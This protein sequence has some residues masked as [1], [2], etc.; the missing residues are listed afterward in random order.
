[1]AQFYR[2]GEISGNSFSLQIAA[3]M[4]DNI[5]VSGTGESSPV[6]L[7]SPN[8]DE[9]NSLRSTRSLANLIAACVHDPRVTRSFLRLTRPPRGPMPRNTVE[10]LANLA[11]NPG[12]EVEPIYRL[13]K[14]GSSYE[15]SLVQMPDAWTITV[16]VNN[17]GDDT[18]LIGGPGNLAFDAR[19]YAWVT[20]N[21]DQGTPYSSHVAMV[22]KPNGQP[23]DGT[24]GT[25]LSPLKGG[26]LL[27]AGFG[28][29]IDPQGSAWFGNFGWGNCTGC[30]PDPDGN[31]SV[32]QFA[33]SGAPISGSLGYQGGPVRAQGMAFDAEG[34]LWISSFGNDSIYVFLHGD[35]NQSVGFQ[36]NIGSGPFDVA[37]AADGSA[38]VSNGL[39]KPPSSVAKYKLVNGAVELQFRR[40]VGQGLRGLSLDSRGNAWVAS[41]GDHFVYVLRPDGTE[42]GRF[43][44]GG[45]EGPW[46]TAIDGE[47]NVWVTNFGPLEP[48]SNFTSGRLTKLAGVHPPP[49][50]NFGDPI[51]PPTGY[52]VHSAGS[53]VLLHNG[54]PLYGA[55]APPSFAPMM[56]QTG[57]VIDQ[58]G[59]VWSINN[60]K[61]DFDIDIALNPGG[62]GI[63]IFCRA[64]A[65]SP[66]MRS[67]A[68]KL[69]RP[70]PY[71]TSV[72]G[73]PPAGTLARASIRYRVRHA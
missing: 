44:G 59:N 2:T 46:D 61:P 58:A 32:S 69:R 19:G 6:L 37:I 27:G 5:V 12:Q 42:I 16:K 10:A 49:G 34:N 48:G 43:N 26:G 67:N 38:W 68:I 53:E 25:P 31:G 66:C 70:R 52:T 39:G 60:W 15:P 71:S 50:K 8:A 63:V 21:V 56:R 18:N 14:L 36:Q 40:R 7:A 9:T 30:D 47:D 73:F 51:S 57:A 54:D 33:A 55:G 35:P 13:T 41:Q 24:N 17:S 11:R 1:M 23:A 65:T 64:C 3:G 22:L 4:N 20:N 28:V 62:D 29:A 45:I 72:T